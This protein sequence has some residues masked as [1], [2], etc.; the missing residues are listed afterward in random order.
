MYFL[1]FKFH[2][3]YVV[4]IGACVGLFVGVISLFILPIPVTHAETRVGGG[5][6]TGETSWNASGSPYILEDNVSIPYGSIVTVEPGVTIT[7]DLVNDVLPELFVEGSLILKGTQEKPITVQNISDIYVNNGT[8]S[9]SH[10][11]ISTPNPVYVRNSHT[12]IAY[13]SFTG[14]WQALNI[15]SGSTHISSSSIEGNGYGIYMDNYMPVM[16][17][18]TM[19]LK[20]VSFLSAVM[21]KIIPYASAQVG[22]TVDPSQEIV[23]I[24]NSSFPRSNTIAISNTFSKPGTIFNAIGNW[25]GSSDGPQSPSFSSNRIIG[26]VNYNPWLDHEPDL[27][28]HI[29]AT[30]TP[31]CSSILFIPGIESS[32]LYRDEKGLF[33]MGVST[34][35]LWEPNRNDDVRALFLDSTGSSIDKTIYS[36]GPI[37]SVWTLS[38]YSSFMKFL[39]GMVGRG[40][41]NSW[42]P[43]GYDWRKPVNEVVLGQEK[44]ATTTESLIDTFTRL[45]KNSKTGKVT[46][47]VHSNGGLVAKYL[48]KIL[49]D[50]GQSNLVDS[51]ISVAVPYLGTP[52]AIGSIL[53]GDDTKLAGGLLLQTDVARQLGQ[54]MSSAYSLLPSAKYYTKVPGPTIFFSSTT[55]KIVNNGA[56]PV[57]ISNASDQSAFIADLKHVRAGA[58]LT[59]TTNPI[60]GN[61]ALVASAGS[62]HDVLDVFSWPVNITRWAIVGWNSL[63]TKAITYNTTRHCISSQYGQSCVTDTSHDTTKTNMGDGTVIAQSASEGSEHVA[64]IDLNATN[65]GKNTHANILE[66]PATQ[67]VVSDIVKAKL[68]AIAQI[69]GVTIGEPDYSKESTYIVMSTHSPIEPHV[70]DIQGN[71]TGAIAPPADTEPG[72][73]R[74]YDQNIPGSLFES[75]AHSDGTYDTYIY[76]PDNGQKYTVSMN[77]TG[78]GEFTFDIDRYRGSEHLNHTEFAN[79]PVTPLTV[80]STTVQLASFNSSDLTSMSSSTFIATIKPLV[81]DIDGNGQVDV[82]AVHDATSTVD[83]FDIL[84]KTCETLDQT[85]TNKKS[86]ASYCKD[87]SKRVDVIKD[88]IKKGKLTHIKNNMSKVAQLMKHRDWKKLKDA[89]R[90]EVGDMIDSFVGQFE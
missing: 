6:I 41:I 60:I 56:Y 55:P 39:D 85:S 27:T 76:V 65:G 62:L 48:V 75:S 11:N 57:T 36:G 80:A 13:S 71:H 14:A 72:L 54:N 20:P 64:S 66:S 77:G 3:V 32:R 84:K 45:A 31:C 34:N 15:K 17:K 63:T 4:C 8:T 74:A 52:Q 51:V 30:S 59:D 42:V 5:M 25:W 38:V 35:T 58:R 40:D 47:L 28:E 83:T 88:K 82:T 49:A 33:G 16:I 70:Y 53:H 1:S 50:R 46:L 90:Q 21:R 29:Q 9:M 68:G 12:D 19:P 86:K 43:F 2:V 61:A 24:S 79:L 26:S 78:V 87:I 7:T 81:I 23:T 10:V 37:D 18:A 67:A 69:P 89:D 44:K 73:Y 22:T